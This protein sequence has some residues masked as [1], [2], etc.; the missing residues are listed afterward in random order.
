[1][2]QNFQTELRNGVILFT[3]NYYFREGCLNTLGISI[4]YTGVTFSVIP[5][6]RMPPGDG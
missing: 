3:I 6:F 2:C 5:H 4:H 1:M